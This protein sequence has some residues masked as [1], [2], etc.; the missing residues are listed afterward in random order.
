MAKNSLTGRAYYDKIISLIDYRGDI[1]RK[2]TSEYFQGYSPDFS[3]NNIKRLVISPEGAIVQLHIAIQGVKTVNYVILQPNIYNI[4]ST[5]EDYIPMLNCLS[6]D[7]ICA[8]IEEVIIIPSSTSGAVQLNYVEQN[9]SGLIKNFRDNGEKDVLELISNR[10]KRLRDF[11]IVSS[12]FKTVLDYI[13]K[14]RDS[15]VCDAEELEVESVTFIHKDDWY[16]NY[17]SSASF[18]LLDA[19]DGK[20]NKHFQQIRDSDESFQYEL[21]KIAENKGY[22]KP[23]QKVTVTEIDVVKNELQ[24]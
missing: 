12:N 13:N 1:K 20:L 17:G 19:K 4:I 14:N 24:E 3:P 22:Y 21:F 18:Y 2:K 16:N 10:Y 6:E 5:M 7:R 9:V 11:C 8:S 23:A 15:F